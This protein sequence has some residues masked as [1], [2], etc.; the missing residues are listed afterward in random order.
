MTKTGGIVSP[1]N[2]NQS[3]IYMVPPQLASLGVY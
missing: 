2:H 1:N 3:D